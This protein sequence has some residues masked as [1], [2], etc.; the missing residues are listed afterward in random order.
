MLRITIVESNLQSGGWH[1]HDAVHWAERTFVV[2]AIEQHNGKISLKGSLMYKTF[3]G[4]KFEIRE[5]DRD[6][7]CVL[8]SN[9]RSSLSFGNVWFSFCHSGQINFSLFRPKSNVRRDGTEK[10]VFIAIWTVVC[11]VSFVP[12]SKDYD[13]IIHDSRTE[14]CCY[15]E[16]L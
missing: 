14:F 3:R 12:F 8:Y 15:H 1:S 10:N 13:R 11:L 5:L 9:S 16:A 4:F 2:R 7:V 6:H